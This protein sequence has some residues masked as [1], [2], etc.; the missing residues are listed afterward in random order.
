MP[1]WLPQVALT[2]NTPPPS[3]WPPAPRSHGKAPTFP[4]LADPLGFV[5]ADD[6]FHLVKAVVATQRDYGR[7][8]VRNQARLKYLIHEW[9]LDKFRAVVE[10]YF[11][12][13]LE[14]FR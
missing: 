9:G 7:R 11:G 14:P 6:V 2:S 13:K 1:Q 8:D 10:Q 4:R 12:K 3:S 5:A